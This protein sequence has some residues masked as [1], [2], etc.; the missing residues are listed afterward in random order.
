MAKRRTKPAATTTSSTTAKSSKQPTLDDLL[1]L[2]DWDWSDKLLDVVEAKIPKGLLDHNGPVSKAQHVIEDL[3]RQLLEA[4]DKL[5]ELL[6]PYFALVDAVAAI[7]VASAAPKPPA[8]KKKPAS[9]VSVAASRGRAGTSRGA[10]PAKT[11]KRVAKA[12][13]PAAA[14]AAA[15]ANSEKK[16]PA[17][18]PQKSGH[19]K[20]LERAAREGAERSLW[21]D[22]A[23]GNDPN[24]WS[25]RASDRI[26]E[27]A[28]TAYLD[29]DRLPA[30]VAAAV[31]TER[32]AVALEHDEPACDECGCMNDTPCPGGC[33]WVGHPEASDKALCSACLPKVRERIGWRSGGGA[34]PAKGQLVWEGELITGNPSQWREAVWKS[35]YLLAKSP[36]ADLSR[37]PAPIVDA[38]VEQRLQWH[39]AGSPKTWPPR[40]PK[41]AAVQ[42]VVNCDEVPA[43]IAAKGRRRKPSPFAK[44]S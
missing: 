42:G 1:D 40:R 43:E 38:V 4:E 19:Q 41:A 18:K 28:A 10:T 24:N 22:V 27:L 30:V 34:A 15:S 11:K 7:K 36:L 44:A 35:I 17:K 12:K 29:L 2:H 8:A 33:Q 20:R 37:L 9:R 14:P 16:P 5:R 13:G 23:L 6:K 32:K 31:V 25:D 3:Q 39:A 26:V 21:D